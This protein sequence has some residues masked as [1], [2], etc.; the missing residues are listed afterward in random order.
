MVRSRN[1]VVSI[2]L[3]LLKTISP[4]RCS[5]SCHDRATPYASVHYGEIAGRV[6]LSVD[7]YMI[8]QTLINDGKPL[9]VSK[10]KNYSRADCLNAKLSTI[11]N[12]ANLRLLNVALEDSGKY[13]MELF[14]PLSRAIYSF[15]IIVIGNPILYIDCKDMVVYEG[16]NISCICKAT[17]MNSSPNSLR[18][19]K[20]EQPNSEVKNFTNILKL[21]NVSRSESGI[22]SCHVKDNNSVNDISF[23]LEV[24]PKNTTA[25]KKEPMVKINCLNITIPDGP[26]LN[27]EKAGI[28]G[29]KIEWQIRTVVAGCS[30]LAGIVMSGVLISSC[31]KLCDKKN[32]KNRYRS[33][34]YDDVSPPP[35][36]EGMKDSWPEEEES[37]HEY[38]VP[39]SGNMER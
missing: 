39:E 38:D 22:Y 12:F 20:T 17:N 18:W 29:N 31:K 16:E 9:T 8:E 15:E 5:K 10:C 4:I 7:A 30:F 34:V 19:K 33:S 36:K 28:D 14:C 25:T 35:A 32:K 6:H 27:K 1:N 37:S 3:L 21:V 24:M 13:I 23:K 11:E 26:C 2:I